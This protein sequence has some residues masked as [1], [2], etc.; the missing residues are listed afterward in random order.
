MM[1]RMRHA[2]MIVGVTDQT[3]AVVGDYLD[4][5]NTHFEQYLDGL[6]LATLV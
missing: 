5:L 6:V 4:A 3:R 2:A 1:N